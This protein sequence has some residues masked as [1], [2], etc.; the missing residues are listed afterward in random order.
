MPLGYPRGEFG[1]VNRKP[2]EEVCGMDRWD[3]PY[4]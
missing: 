2:W 1:S 3:N 4:K